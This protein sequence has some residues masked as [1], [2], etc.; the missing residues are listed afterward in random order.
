MQFWN[1]WEIQLLVLLSFT[2][3]IFLFFT[4]VFRR[5]ST[6]MLLRLPIWL[7]YLGADIVAVYALGFM[8]RREDTASRCHG[9]DATEAASHP[10]VFFWAPFLLIHLGGQDTITAF[11][12]EDNN[13]WLRHL[14]NLVVQVGLA[15]YVFWSS[16]LR[17][18]LQLLAAAIFV[19]L[20]G[21]IKY[22]ERI[23]ALKSASQ[24][25]LRSSTLSEQKQQLP[26]VNLE[27]VTY[28]GIVRFAL[29]TTVVV[30]GFFA[31]FTLTELED[32]HSGNFLTDFDIY[33]TD[34]A[35]KV[36]EMELG[37]MYDD[38]YSK[39]IVLRTWS[40]VMLRFVSQL[41]TVV[42]FGIFIASSKQRHG[43]VDVGITYV[44]FIG[45]FF[46]EICSMIMMMMSPWTWEFLEARKC[47]MPARMSWYVLSTVFPSTRA[48]W[49]N[50]IGQYN[51]LSSYIRDQSGFFKLL[52]KV[53]VVVG[54]DKMWSDFRHSSRIK[55]NTK[56]ILACVQH[57][58]KPFFYSRRVIKTG[59]QTNR[60]DL[61]PT[62]KILLG[63]PLEYAILTL[64]LFTDLLL[65]DCV[66]GNADYDPTQSH[67]LKDMSEKLS[68]YMIYLLVV[69]PSM[70]PV[71]GTAREAL[72]QVSKAIRDCRFNNKKD[73]RDE[74][75]KGETGKFAG[76]QQLEVV[77]SILDHVGPLPLHDTLLATRDTWVGLLLYVAGKSRAAARQRSQ[78][79]RE[80]V[81]IPQTQIDRTN[82]T[83][84]SISSRWSILLNHPS[85][86]TR[87]EKVNQ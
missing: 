56:E 38:L 18:D 65:S 63:L 14:L 73:I 59:P 76:I 37:I 60:P 21:I 41:S 74:V 23:W 11:A 13:L 35:Q 77:K 12:M 87:I 82:C 22:W 39:A 81:C 85:S 66:P 68:N 26:Q 16:S 79:K 44:L 20:A 69:N 78:L 71:T 42:A 6:S 55:A 40:G 36:V 54:L 1:D 15:L 53:M 80:G 64:H 24:G 31:G 27:D 2:L 52:A 29:H 17:H 48:L 32:D 10:L 72:A 57:Q 70:L 49:S 62:L 9:R 58:V 67:H 25:G 43:G 45:V 33:Y 19:S 3:Q 28:S 8:S 61:G 34:Q 75:V 7:A 4:G 86:L 51:L 5:C 30:R 83:Q 47:H 46:L 84:S 50:S